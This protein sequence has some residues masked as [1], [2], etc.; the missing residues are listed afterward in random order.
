[1]SGDQLDE[2]QIYRLNQLD[3][4]PLPELQS[5]YRKVVNELQEVKVEFE[6][7]QCKYPTLQGSKFK[8]VMSNL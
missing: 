2:D 7:F 5:L 6:E 4:I 8:V 1:M 3:E